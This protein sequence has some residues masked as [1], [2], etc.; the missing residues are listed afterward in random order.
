MIHKNFS[1]FT[2]A[3]DSY[4]KP[5]STVYFNPILMYENS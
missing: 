4:E 1:I 5:V 3:K 2:N